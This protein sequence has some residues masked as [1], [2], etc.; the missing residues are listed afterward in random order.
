MSFWLGK[1]TFVTGG[2]GLLGAWLVKGLLEKGAHVVCLKH[3]RDPHIPAE[4][5]H[6][7][8]TIHADLTD[9]TSIE[10][11]LKERQIEVV[12][13]LAAQAIV[14]VANKDPV[15]TFETNIRGTWA[16]LEAC[17]KCPNVQQIV[18]GSSDKAYGAHDKLPYTEA[19]A[20]NAKH[21]YDASKACGDILAQTYAHSY[22]LPVAITRC[23]NF[24]G[25]GDLN[26]NRIVPSTIQ[27]FLR[28]EPPVI[29]SDGM[30]VRDYFY[31][32]DG[33]AAAMSLAEA[34]AQNRSLKGHAFNFSNE[35]QVTVLD[36]VEKIRG[37][38]GS[39]LQPVILNQAS[40][41]IRNQYLS[42]QKARE[43]LGWKPLFTLEAGLQKTID[44][45]KEYLAK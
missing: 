8:Q 29:R 31:V 26:W 41:E 10:S 5:S 11:I 30:F 4:F 15:G 17:R 6:R 35:L 9:Q 44:W 7:V 14:G 38:M 1:R 16:V 25:G 18:Y 32:E 43:M 2:T 42:A 34:L 13:H 23:G 20:L 28:G 24:Y 36:L 37:L 12:L 39:T 33:A 22:E 27:S 45:Y 21:P 3:S 19:M 40:N